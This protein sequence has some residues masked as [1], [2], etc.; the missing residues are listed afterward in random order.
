MSH[1]EAFKAIFSIGRSLLMDV[2]REYRALNLDWM[3]HQNLEAVI[4]RSV[5]ESEREKYFVQKGGYHQ[6]DLKAVEADLRLAES[7]ADL[8]DLDNDELFYLYSTKMQRRPKL[9]G[10]GHLARGPSGLSR[11]VWVPVRSLNRAIRGAG[12]AFE[13][14]L[15][16]T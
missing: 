12:A 4:F 7:P 10:V 11:P 5:S 9:V 1:D 6:L 2:I 14:L 3:I 13:K 15:S 8:F 16:G